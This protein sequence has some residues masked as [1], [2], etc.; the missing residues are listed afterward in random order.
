M[1]KGFQ[2][3]Q[4]FK[5]FPA[6]NFQMNNEAYGFSGC[7]LWLDAAYGLNTQ[8]DGASISSWQSRIGETT[9]IQKTAGNQF[10]YEDSLLAFNNYPAILSN[11]GARFMTS[12]NSIGLS[13][14]FTIAFVV[15]RTSAIQQANVICHGNLDNISLSAT[16]WFGAGGNFTASITGYGFYNS[17][18]GAVAKIVSTNEDSNA[19][20]VII[21]NNTLCIDG[22]NVVTSGNAI[23]FGSI[24]CLGYN[25]S[26]APWGGYLGE[27]LIYS[28]NKLSDSDC[29]QLSDRLNQ[30]YAIY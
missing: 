11:T 10:S 16:D 20:I 28:N 14:N 1:F 6:L 19:H 22:V 30:K 25:N 23:P 12:N 26:N 3:G 24:N 8:T 13:N 9:F 21:T 4:Q 29:I 5:G 2:K 15:Q 7:T 27:M 18:A 17:I